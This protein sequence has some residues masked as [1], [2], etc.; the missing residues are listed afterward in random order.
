MA[1]I[2][3]VR[4]INRKPT[5]L[6]EAEEDIPEMKE[7]NPDKNA[8]LK[9][10]WQGVKQSWGELQATIKADKE[11]KNKEK[12]D[13]AQEKISAIQDRLKYKMAE[14]Q[15]RD[16]AQKERELT[17]NPVQSAVSGFRQAGQG[18]GALPP[19]SNPMR[20]ML[21]PRP[22][23][24]YGNSTGNSVILGLL[25]GQ[26][27]QPKVKKHYVTIIDGKEVRRVPAPNQNQQP[28]QVPNSLIERMALG[29]TPFMG[30]KQTP[31]YEYSQSK[32]IS[33]NPMADRMALGNS[34]F[35]YNFTTK[36]KMRYM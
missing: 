32:G 18:R 21:A 11:R 8:D 5:T 33:R 34:K 22:S 36:K 17:T 19:A 4:T 7:T 20:D 30:T 9:E 26:A 25:S 6:S 35:G 16:L 3:E 28:A 15:A 29:A 24:N 23:M 31:T 14:K 13:K 27:A 12:Y 1:D 10:S 2:Q